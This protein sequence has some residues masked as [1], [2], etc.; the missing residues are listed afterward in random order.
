MASG[1]RCCAT[2]NNDRTCFVVEF[3]RG[4]VRP[5]VVSANFA[6]YC[7]YPLG[8]MWR[9]PRRAGASLAQTG[10]WTDK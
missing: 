5:A 8:P 6:A 4:A 3:D 7:R 9:R 10:G 1:L 2:M